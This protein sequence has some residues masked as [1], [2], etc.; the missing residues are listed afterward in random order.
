MPFRTAVEKLG[1]RRVSSYGP[2]AGWAAVGAGFVLDQV[3]AMPVAVLRTPP[4]RPAGATAP[5]RHRARWF[6][7]ATCADAGG[8]QHIHAVITATVHS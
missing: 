4:G 6:P 7:P 8:G 1:H 2:A 3:G 5:C